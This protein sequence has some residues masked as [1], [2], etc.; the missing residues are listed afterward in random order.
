MP[1]QP[2]CLFFLLSPSSP[3]GL[4]RPLPRPRPVFRPRGRVDRVLFFVTERES[5]AESACARRESAE[6]KWGHERRR[7]AFFFTR[8]LHWRCCLFCFLF[9]AFFSPPL[10]ARRALPVLALGAEP[11]SVVERFLREPE[12]QI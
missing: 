4:S 9:F 3:A 10:G 8:R 5:G 7:Q 2:L 11:V 6:T 12:A 1:P